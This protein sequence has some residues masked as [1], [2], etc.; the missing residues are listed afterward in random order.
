MLFYVVKINEAGSRQVHGQSGV[1]EII[2]NVAYILL[3]I[4]NLVSFA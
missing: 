1:E 4:S 3:F 2:T